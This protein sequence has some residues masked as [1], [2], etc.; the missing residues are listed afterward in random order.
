[1]AQLRLVTLLLSVVELGCAAPPSPPA[2]PSSGKPGAFNCPRVKTP[3][4]P[5]LDITKLH[6]GHVSIVMAMGDSITAGFSARSDLYEARDISFSSGE[7]G[8]DQ[9]TLPWLLSQYSSKVEGAST[10]KHLV[11]DFLHLP[12]ADYVPDTDKLNVAESSGAVHSGSLD[13]QW[14]YLVEH[15]SNYSNFADRWKV[16]TIFMVADDISGSCYVPIGNNASRWG[17]EYGKLFSKIESKLTRTYVNL[18][19]LLDLSQIHRIQQGRLGCKLKHLLIDEAGC[20][21][22][23][24]VTA[25]Q[26]AL[27]DSNIHALNSQLHD[28]AKSWNQKFKDAGRTDMYIAVQGFLEHQGKTLD[29]TFL[30]GFDCFHPSKEAHQQLAIALWDSMLCH[31]RKNLC[32]VKVPGPSLVC[33]TEESVFYTGPDVVPTPPS[34][35]QA[36][37]VV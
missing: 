15:F 27:L 5:G 23:R 25:A 36:G 34:V 33:P 11:K 28:V 32:G 2:E 24:G 30:S 22:K 14:G 12:H 13:E 31:D 6:P 20:V 8:E 1:M 7:G 10:K 29:H 17:A 19:P 26:L 35:W 21:D 37:F 18:I 3:P 9:L 16:L 4:E